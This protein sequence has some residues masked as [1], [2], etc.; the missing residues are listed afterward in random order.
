[1]EYHPVSSTSLRWALLLSI[2]TFLWKWDVW[3]LP[4]IFCAFQVDQILIHQ[5]TA[6][7]KSESSFL[8]FF[9]K[10]IRSLPICEAF[11]LT[12]WWFL[13]DCTP[14]LNQSDVIIWQTLIIFFTVLTRFETNNEYEIK[15]STGQEIYHAKEE[16]D[17]LVHN[18]FGPARAFKMHI[19]NHMDQEI[20][21]MHRPMRCFLSEV[22]QTLS[23]LSM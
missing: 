17:C 23:V 10:C 4:R 5:K 3:M 21:Q 11:L 19:T 18:I 6:C 20:I 1:M 14:C 8:F 22:E 7:I 9:F 13:K 16:S 15:N 2:S 12:L